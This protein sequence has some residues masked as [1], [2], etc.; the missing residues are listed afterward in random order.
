M[1]NKIKLFSQTIYLTKNSNLYAKG[2]HLWKRPGLSPIQ[3]TLEY[4]LISP[5]VQCIHN[6][7]NGLYVVMLNGDVIEYY[8][9]DPSMGGGMVWKVAYPVIYDKNQIPKHEYGVIFN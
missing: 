3:L 4:Q 2:N 9:K 5:K 1:E 8:L 6:S 7:K